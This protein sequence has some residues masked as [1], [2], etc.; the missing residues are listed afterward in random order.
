M[1]LKGFHVFFIIVAATFCAAMAAW[2]FVGSSSE[3]LG[4]FA[5][6]FGIS[7]I[8]GSLLLFTYGAWF[9]LRKSRTLIV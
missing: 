3:V 6:P 9:V 1:S 4:G 5:K 7:A 8:V 2:A